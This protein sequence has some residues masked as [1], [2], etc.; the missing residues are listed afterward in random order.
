MKIAITGGTGFIGSAL[1]KKLLEQKHEVI[2]LCRNIPKTNI[3]KNVTYIQWLTNKKIDLDALEN[4][5]CI[6]NLAGATISKRWTNDYKKQIVTSRLE[7]TNE[8]LKIIGQLKRKPSILI[9]ASA[10]GFY[11]TSETKIFTERTIDAGNDFLATTC[12]QWEELALTAKDLGTTRIVL[13]RF[14]L[15][16]DSHNGALPKI[17][18]PYRSLVGGNLGSGK[19]WYSWIHIDDCVGSIIHILNTP[20]IDGAI[21]LVAPTP[22]SMNEFG[23]CLA[24]VLKRPHYFSASGF[25]IQTILGEMS[26]LVLKGQRV[27]PEKLLET[28]YSF[29]YP[30]LTDALNSLYS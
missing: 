4:T 1:S 20:T 30:H 19:Q 25:L 9:N 10:I 15:I 24:K 17:V 18:L 3:I 2:I 7:A 23:K 16:L 14:G 5:D 12:K 28:N 26:M 8:V 21:N 6:I 11:G 22:V 29:K 13:A 27:F